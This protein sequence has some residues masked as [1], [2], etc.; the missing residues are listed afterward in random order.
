MVYLQPGF[1]Q[2]NQFSVGGY[3]F[4]ITYETTSITGTPRCSF[5]YQEQRLDFVGKEIQVEQTQLGQLVTVRLSSKTN[6]VV[7][8]F[9]NNPG[10][11]GLFGNKIESQDEV[12]ERLTLLIPT[13]NLAPDQVKSPVQIL[14]I[15]SV[16]SRT[17]KTLGQ[18]QYCMP[19]SLYGTASKLD[20]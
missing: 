5:T 2:A 17:G 10:N 4:G 9:G 20:F 6:Q 11:Q 3:Q 13:V 14:A 1:M 7:G 18:S 16:R 19:L 12:I 8:F 15:F